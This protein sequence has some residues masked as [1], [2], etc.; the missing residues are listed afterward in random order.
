MIRGYAPTPGPGVCHIPGP[1]RK[2]SQQERWNPAFLE[3]GPEASC[4][5]FI[6]GMPF[7]RQTPA[8]VWES[9]NRIDDLD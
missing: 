4:R 9:T 5:E 8:N 2:I 7:S 6:C 3:I 1:L